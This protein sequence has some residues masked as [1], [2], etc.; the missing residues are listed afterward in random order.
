MWGGSIVG[1]TCEYAGSAQ[2]GLGSPAATSPYITSNRV[3]AVKQDLYQGGLACGRCYKVT[4][5]NT[6]NTEEDCGAA[7]STIIQVVGTG[8]GIKEFDCQEG[9]YK[10]ITGCSTGEVAITYEEVECEGMGNPTATIVAQNEQYKTDH[11]MVFSN[12]PRPV[13]SGSLVFANGDSFDLSLVEGA[14]DVHTPDP[15]DSPVTFKLT[16][17][18]GRVVELTECFSNWPRP[19]GDSCSVGSDPVP[20]TSGS[21]VPTTTVP[22]TTVPTTSGSPTTTP[23][24]CVAVWGQCGGGAD[25]AGSTCCA[26]GSQ[27]VAVSQWYS[28]CRPVT[29]P[30]SGCAALWGQCGGQD[31]AGPTCCAQ[32][33]HCVVVSQWY[34][35]C[36][37]VRRNLRGLPRG[38]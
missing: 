21:P 2:G 6:D 19:D 8:H 32:N 4:F 24:G 22:T 33:T 1:S 26:A 18:D 5:D 3:C 10:E 35:Q 7:G 20:T 28:Q 16:L 13:A 11:H 12:L 15:T 25:F 31:F 9:G 17:D 27:C 14:W 34:S 30:P 38:E 37:P 23:S 29:P 36:L